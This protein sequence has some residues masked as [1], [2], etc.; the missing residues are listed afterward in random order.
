M[1]EHGINKFYIGFFLAASA[2]HKIA[3]RISWLHADGSGVGTAAI[4]NCAAWVTTKCRPI[5]K[6]VIQVRNPKNKSQESN[7]PDE[8]VTG[9]YAAY[10]DWSM[11][12]LDWLLLRLAHQ[13]L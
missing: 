9:D 11:F 3:L 4:M 8:Y 13:N 12:R 2:W 10:P 1:L 5:Q 7:N 6:V